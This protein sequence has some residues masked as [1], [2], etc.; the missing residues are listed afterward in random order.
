MYLLNGLNPACG[1]AQFDH[2]PMQG[3]HIDGHTASI[4]ALFIM[5]GNRLCKPKTYSSDLVL[6]PSPSRAHH[7]PSCHDG[8]AHAAT[9]VFGEGIFIPILTDMAKFTCDVTFDNPIG[10]SQNSA[11]NK[12]LKVIY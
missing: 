7:E 2:N 11:W 9:G 6:Q 5:H 3:C 4:S 12:L 10:I 1:V 8:V